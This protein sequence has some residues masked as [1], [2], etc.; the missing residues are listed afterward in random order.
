MPRRTKDQRILGRFNK[1][2][3]RVMGI[4]CKIQL[5]VDAKK[6]K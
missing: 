6:M 3:L 4:L 1:K 5:P 2:H